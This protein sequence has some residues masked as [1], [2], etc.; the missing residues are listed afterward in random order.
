MHQIAS[1]CE[2]L[3]KCVSDAD[4][5]L[6]IRTSIL[7]GDIDKAL[8]RT[9]AYYPQ[10]LQDHSQI[11]FKLR[12]RKF[13][14]M[15]RQGAELLDVPITKR[16][17]SANGHSG[18]NTDDDFEPDMELDDPLNGSDDWDKMETEEAENGVKYQDLLQDTLRYGQE[19][20]TEFKD[21]DDPDKVVQ[22]TFRDIWSFFAYED[23]RKSP[24]AHLL[25]PQGRVPVA[26]ELNSAILGKSLATPTY[27]VHQS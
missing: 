13:L 17:K 15:I 19:L 8:K 23:P 26:E 27:F 1:V 16:N 3:C 11:Y 20:Q 24:V 6:D 7:D 9:R 22:E 21:K 14:E 2:P 5:F 25:D 18:T 4:R 12:C 10:V